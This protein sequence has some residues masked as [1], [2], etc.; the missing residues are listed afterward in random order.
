MSG[1]GLDPAHVNLYQRGR[2]R[3]ARARAVLQDAGWLVLRSA[4]SKTPV[5]LVAWAPW[6]WCWMIQVK[7]RGGGVWAA[8]RTVWFRWC[9]Q[10]GADAVLVRPDRLGH[11]QWQIW[12]DARWRPVHPAA[13]WETV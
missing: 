11:L 7:P 12:R 4:G 2:G 3:E 5:D 13:T 9:A 8:D 6:G 1:R 10:A